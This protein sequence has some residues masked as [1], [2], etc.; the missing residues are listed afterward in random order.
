MSY[1]TRFVIG[2]V[3]VLLGGSSLMDFVDRLGK[4][5]KPSNSI[6]GLL[7]VAGGIWL[8]RGYKE[9]KRMQLEAKERDLVLKVKQLEKQKKQLEEQT[10]EQ[11]RR[12]DLGSR[13]TSHIGSSS[14]KESGPSGG[15][16]A[17]MLALKM[18]RALFR[19]NRCEANPRGEE[20]GHVFGYDGVCVYCRSKKD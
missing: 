10:N 11:A 15:A 19:D 6:F 1:K 17:G 4:S 13:Q 8:L 16:V 9:A 14:S 18:V 12:T 3:L 7:A 5:S 20:K 2:I